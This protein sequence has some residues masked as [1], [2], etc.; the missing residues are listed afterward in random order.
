MVPAPLKTPM[1]SAGGRPAGPRAD[2]TVVV[3]SIRAGG[4]AVI[5]L[6]GGVDSALVASLAFEALGD[7]AVAA[8]VT[9]SA[10]APREAAR[11]ARMATS[12][13][14]RHVVL[15]AEPLDRPEYRANGPDRCYFC[16][17]V[18]TTAL[19][20]FGADFGA[21]QYLD[22][23]HL[24]DLSDDRPGLRAMNGAGFVHPLLDA[25]W[26]KDE[27]R[28]AAR[29]RG[30]ANWDQPS[31]ACLSSR[32]ARGEPIDAKLLARIDAAESWLL[33]HGFHRVRVRARSG[34]ARIEVGPD[35]LGRL[36]TE[37]LASAA[38]QHL[39]ALG[40][41]PVTIDPRGYRGTPPPLIALR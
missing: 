13:G 39:T 24:D 20:S 28:A 9:N 14:I 37:P 19:R 12:I 7:R 31:D 21:R 5:A 3:A 25:G 30:L 40:F 27:V 26:R 17:V 1:E 34:G 29:R 32:V 22:G 15:A 6:S 4:P 8:T 41:S 10:L 11:A 33:E 16:R 23:I 38:V 36:S 18:E 35:E 2:D